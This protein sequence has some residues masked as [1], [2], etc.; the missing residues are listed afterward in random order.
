MSRK[1]SNGLER[2]DLVRNMM[3]VLQCLER[4]KEKLFLFSKYD[5][6]D[7]E[8]L[9]TPIILF[10]KSELSKPGVQREKG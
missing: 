7:G 3:E 9:L 6:S 10:R 2:I 5:F 1:T 4:S 8:T